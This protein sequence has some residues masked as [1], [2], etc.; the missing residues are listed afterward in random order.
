[1]SGLPSDSAFGNGSR[2]SGR[3]A[4]EVSD[5]PDHFHGSAFGAAKCLA[6][7]LSG[8]TTYLFVFSRGRGIQLT[9]VS[10]CAG[11]SSAHADATDAN[12]LATCQL[13]NQHLD[14]WTT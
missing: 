10:H 7:C 12:V 3:W 4:F 2:A 8:N 13:G 14:G 5:A 11:D 6:P 9:A 1:M